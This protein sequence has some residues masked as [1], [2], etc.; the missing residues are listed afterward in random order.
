M[1]QVFSYG[2]NFLPADERGDDDAP[3]GAAAVSAWLLR[4]GAGVGGFVTLASPAT[5]PKWVEE[6]EYEVQAQT[7]QSHGCEQQYRLGDEKEKIFSGDRNLIIAH[8]SVGY[9]FPVSLWVWGLA[10]SLGRGQ[11]RKWVQDTGK[12]LADI[13]RNQIH[14]R[15]TC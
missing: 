4:V 2:D 8:Y 14:R 6:E 5:K 7:H 15:S 10:L 11:F 9:T 12:K 13:G 3:G 1:S